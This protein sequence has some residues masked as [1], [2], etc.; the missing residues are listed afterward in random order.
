MSKPTFPQHFADAAS[1]NG[2]KEFD[3]VLVF[4]T[5]PDGQGTFMLD[6]ACNC[7]ICTQ[8]LLLG[9]SIVQKQLE[10]GLKRAIN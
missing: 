3:N 1:K 4:Y 7:L 6:M 8:N 5:M 10:D 2:A 9:L